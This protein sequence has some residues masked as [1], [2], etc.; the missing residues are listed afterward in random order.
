LCLTGR[1]DET[2]NINPEPQV[3]SFP[4]SAP[5]LI[6]NIRN[7]TKIELGT[8]ILQGEEQSG[9]LFPLRFSCFLKFS[10]LSWGYNTNQVE[11]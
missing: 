9:V 4:D 10:I 3:F 11:W 8:S 6:K 2:Q 1:P 7:K 5:E